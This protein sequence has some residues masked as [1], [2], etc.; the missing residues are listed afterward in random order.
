MADDDVLVRAPDRSKPVGEGGDRTKAATGVG[1]VSRTRSLQRGTT[2]TRSFSLTRDARILSSSDFVVEDMQG[3]DGMGD[4]QQSRAERDILMT[5]ARTRLEALFAGT[6]S[7]MSEAPP[8]PDDV[9]E[10]N[11]DASASVAASALAA[12]LGASRGTTADKSDFLNT[13]AGSVDSMK[14]GH[15]GAETG[16]GG[17]STHALGGERKGVT[18]PADRHR[19]G[20][21][22]R[23]AG[24][25]PKVVYAKREN[26]LSR[27]AHRMSMR[28]N[29]GSSAP[30]E[31]PLTEPPEQEGV[32]G[33]KPGGA[34]SATVLR[35]PNSAL[36]SP[37]LP[38]S[39]HLPE[40]G[41]HDSSLKDKMKRAFGRAA[42]KGTAGGKPVY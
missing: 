8:A 22:P 36:L 1:D 3:T 30:L 14:G 11:S 19:G 13:S 27:V 17:N 9:P 28:L 37:G 15:S 29:R 4:R 40:I 25:K 2:A 26:S 34:A 31:R 33:M 20:V 35:S 38:S 32:I 23:P 16:S 24:D 42:S 6:P 10:P 5:S 21:P 39:E 7:E 18:S 41:R 12:A